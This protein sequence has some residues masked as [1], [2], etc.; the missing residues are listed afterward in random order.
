M[1]N[2]WGEVQREYEPTDASL[3][4][5]ELPDTAGRAHRS[6][7]YDAR[8]RVVETT[9]FNGATAR[10]EYRP[11]EVLLRDAG[12]ADTPRREEVDV[13]ADRVRTVQE[14]GDGEAVTTSFDVNAAG[15]LVAVHDDSGTLSVAT[16]DRRGGRLAVDHR[17]GG[18]RRIFRDARGTVVRSLDAGGRDLR[19]DIDAQG[20]VARLTQDGVIVEELTYDD[21]ARSALGRLASVSYPGRSPGPVL[22]RGGPGAAPRVRVRRRRPRR[23]A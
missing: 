19:A 21:A 12:R 17:E 22:R 4:A 6:T 14:L 20:R 5:F 18:V 7:R 1:R 10:A 8:G 15:D 9:D 11:F 23:R 3:L 13:L 2:P 16:Y